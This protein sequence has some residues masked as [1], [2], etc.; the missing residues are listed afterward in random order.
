MT[1][2]ER[3]LTAQVQSLK[4]QVVEQAKKIERMTKG[5]YK[6]DKREAAILARWQDLEEE[7]AERER[8]VE[9]LIAE[10]FKL[11]REG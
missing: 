3:R 11:R 1:A 4:A 8:E 10:A 7:I 5:K 9:K 2:K 6:S